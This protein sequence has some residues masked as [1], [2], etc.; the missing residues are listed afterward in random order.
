MSALFSNTFSMVQQ[1]RDIT[2]YQDVVIEQFKRKQ[3][4]PGDDP[5]LAI[6][7]GSLGVDLVL[8]YLREHCWC[9][10][11]PLSARSTLLTDPCRTEYY[12]YNVQA[13]LVMFW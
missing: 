8:Y 5:E 3:T 2:W 11:E 13:M 10:W 7:G 6:A 1:G 4:L 12:S 9:R